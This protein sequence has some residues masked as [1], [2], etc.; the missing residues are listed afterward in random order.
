[1]SLIKLRETC[2]DFPIYGASTRSLKKQLLRLGRRRSQLSA[3]NEQVITVQALRNI[4]LELHEGD[5][6]GLIGSN[7]AGKSTFLR[8]VAGIYT[9]T[10]GK[11]TV[12]G[13]ISAILDIMLGLNEEASGYENITLRG[14]I[15]GLNY[16]QIHAKAA[17]IADFT[18]LK[19]GLNLPIRTYSSGMR[20]RLAFSIA[21]SMI[22]EI[23][24]LDEVVGV[25][26]AEFVK[27]A[28]ARLHEAIN[29]SAIMLLASHSDSLITKMCNRIIWLEKGELKFFGN[30]EE[31]FQRYNAQ[32]KRL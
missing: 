17:E 16:R 13:K 32:I 7:G 4:S 1:M 9:P 23:L 30:I 8:M 21:T 3:D 26:D 14:I 24:V 11:I 20:L 22:S 29:E 18:G 10:R 15:A 25:G 2:I 6:V 19:E 27:R 12:R 5:R 28:D 31:G